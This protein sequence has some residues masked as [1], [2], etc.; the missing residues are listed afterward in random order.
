MRRCTSMI[1]AVVAAGTLLT[2][3]CQ[4]EPGGDTAT[5]VRIM[6]PNRPGSGYDIT[7]RTVAKAFEDAQILREVEVFNLPGTD[8][9][10]GLQRL[11]YE[12]GN[13]K[14]LMLMG[15]GLV[16]SQYAHQSRATLADT[17]PIARLM[18]E[19]NV[20]VV[21]RD[22]PYQTLD[23]LITAW[24]QEPASMTVGGGS[25]VGGPDHLAAMLFAQAVGLA[26]RE[27][28]YVNYDGG[29]ALLAAILGRQVSFG[30]SGLGE[31]GAHIQS[32]QLRALAVTSAKPIADLAAPTLRESGVDV[33]F[34]NW[35]GIVAPPGLS[36]ADVVDL[37]GIVDRLHNSPEW[38]QALARNEW[39]D[40]YLPGDA[41]TSFVQDE[42]GRV[43]RVL[44]ALGLT[45]ES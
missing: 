16:G 29:G 37:R 38:R 28:R 32:G 41:F 9:T 30:V 21:T 45:R 35:R 2:A 25:A 15:L 18:E 20:I 42:S 44:T 10:V 34:T 5:S 39:T 36:D 1:A 22:S 31:Y 40:A 19:P 8:G 33:V 24:R 23:D 6:V 11:A 43:E 3:G 4:A 26:P 12:R 27:A 14:L 13:G 17:T 7:A